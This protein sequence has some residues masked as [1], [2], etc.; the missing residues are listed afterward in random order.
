MKKKKRTFRMVGTDFC[1]KFFL[2]RHGKGTWTLVAG[3]VPRLRSEWPRSSRRAGWGGGH[4]FREPVLLPG[5]SALARA[6]L[7]SPPSFLS[8]RLSRRWPSEALQLASLPTLGLATASGPGAPDLPRS[9]PQPGCRGVPGLGVPAPPPAMAPWAGPAHRWALQEQV[10]WGSLDPRPSHPQK[11]EGLSQTPWG[12]CAVPLDLAPTLAPTPTPTPTPTPLLDPV[13][14]LPS[15]TAGVPGGVPGTP[16]RLSWGLGDEPGFPVGRARGLRGTAGGDRWPRQT[17]GSAVLPGHIR[18]PTALCDLSPSHNA[19]A[20]SAPLPLQGQAAPPGQQV[21]ACFHFHSISPV[22][23][24]R[25]E[26]TW[27]SRLLHQSRHHTMA[28]GEAGLVE[29]DSG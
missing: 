4:G 2:C 21:G 6:S 22:L 23:R 26:G 20:P 1:C 3:G 17:A 19:S 18:S 29:G 8:P 10:V 14:P 28:P 24:S 15:A 25:V 5:A 11:S 12:P 9:P 13:A 7:A 27:L 16:L